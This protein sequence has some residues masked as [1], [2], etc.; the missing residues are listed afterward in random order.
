MSDDKVRFTSLASILALPVPLKKPNEEYRHMEY[1]GF[2]VRVM[3]AR[4]D[5]KV[6]RTYIHRYK[7]KVS[8]GA[9]GY[10]RVNENDILGLVEKVDPT[11]VA[12]E[13]KEALKRY[14]NAHTALENE[15]DEVVDDKKEQRLTVAGA[16]AQYSTEKRVNSPRTIT[17]DTEIYNRYYKHLQDRYLDELTHAFWKEFVLQ[18]EEGTLVVGTNVTENRT[19]PIFRGPLSAGSMPGVVNV[20]ITLYSIAETYDGLYGVEKGYCPLRKVKAKQLK[21]PPKRKRH[22]PLK[23]LGLAWRAA[24]QLIAPWWKDLFQLYVLTGLR[25]SLMVNMR[26]DEI[27]WERGLYIFPPDKEGTKRR[28][29]DITDESEP[30]RLPFSKKAMEILRARRE[31][32]PDKEGWVWFSPKP[33]RGRRTK[34]E[35]ARLSDP[36]GAW[37]LIEDALGGF[38]F[39]PHDLR[40]TFATAGMKSTGRDMFAVALLMLHTST[41]LAKAADLPEITLDYINTDEAQDQMRK[42]A[43]CIADYIDKL[44]TMDAG[45]SQNIE[46]P[47]LPNYIEDALNVRDETPSAE[48]QDEDDEAL[49]EDA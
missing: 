27:D 10:K 38:H 34:K 11:D 33:T 6:R 2:F 46:D 48:E 24:E 15:G 3:R 4:K 45:Q 20:G 37:T 47:V 25:R 26:F 22:I 16:W 39:S 42:A 44:V 49:K 28:H 13:Y 40:R 32:A 35:R 12:I 5:G 29:R 7:K 23:Q 21:K 17:K 31:F 19:D 1:K 36:R 18:L 41:T 8:D 43:N 9:G 14:L 30:I